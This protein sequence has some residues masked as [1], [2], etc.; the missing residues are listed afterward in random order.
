MPGGFKSKK[1]KAVSSANMSRWHGP[2]QEEAAEL[3]AETMIE[4]PDGATRAPPPRPEP[5]PV[6]DEHIALLE[7]RV[8]ASHLSVRRPR[9]CSAALWPDGVCVRRRRRAHIF[10]SQCGRSEQEAP[11]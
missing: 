8:V 3:D 11:G 6:A 4:E 10:V 9:I 1:S 5:A 7:L 2:M